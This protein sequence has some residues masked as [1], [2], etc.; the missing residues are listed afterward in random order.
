MQF[1][2]CIKVTSKYLINKLVDAPPSSPSSFWAKQTKLAKRLL[3]K[4]PQKDFWL[5]AAFPQKYE[6]LL[7]LMGKKGDIL[8]KNLQRQFYYKNPELAI[9]YIEGPQLRGRKKKLSKPYKKIID[10]DK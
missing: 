3:S 4:Y 2:F 10:F 8:I 6:D 7:Y 1:F 9:E 5:K